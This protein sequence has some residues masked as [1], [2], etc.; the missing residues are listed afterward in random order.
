MPKSGDSPENPGSDGPRSHA[1]SPE[2]GAFSS[3]DEGIGQVYSRTIPGKFRKYPEKI[4]E[5]FPWPPQGQTVKYRN[6]VRGLV[7]CAV[8]LSWWH[9]C[10][11]LRSRYFTHL[12]A[13]HA[14]CDGVFGHENGKHHKNNMKCIGHF[15]ECPGQFRKISGNV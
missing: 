13:P 4:T 10:C 14:R 8:S 15:Q 3:P 11:R 9:S 6:R 5:H 7:V 2:A 1:T 12:R